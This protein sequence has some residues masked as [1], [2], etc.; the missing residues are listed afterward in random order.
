MDIR[1]EL[2]EKIHLL[3]ELERLE[4]NEEFKHLIKELYL[5]Q[6]CSNSIKLSTYPTQ[7]Q[8]FHIARARAVGY[9]EQFLQEIRDQGEQAEDQLSKYLSG[10]L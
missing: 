4:Q 9:F 5:N 8:E 1:E 3:R 10:E 6:F 2:E 7:N